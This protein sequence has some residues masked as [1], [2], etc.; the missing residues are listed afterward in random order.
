MEL[1]RDWEN[2]RMRDWDLRE[3]GEIGMGGGIYRKIWNVGK[4]IK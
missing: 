2:E 1:W 3:S 4:N